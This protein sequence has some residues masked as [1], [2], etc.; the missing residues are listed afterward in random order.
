MM[1]VIKILK[2]IFFFGHILLVAMHVVSLEK[3]KIKLKFLKLIMHWITHHTSY[4]WYTNSSCTYL[5]RT[6]EVSTPLGNS[7]FLNLNTKNSPGKQIAHQT[8]PS[9]KIFGSTHPYSLREIREPV[10]HPITDW[11]MTFDFSLSH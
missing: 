11:A 6:G 7:N 9:N 2:L 5:G 1:D 10:S 4:Y 3:K 8:P